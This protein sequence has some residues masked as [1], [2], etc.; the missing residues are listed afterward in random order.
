MSRD[1]AELEAT[2]ERF[3]AD[4]DELRGNLH[5]ELGWAPK[6]LRWIVPI[7]ALAAGVVAGVALKRNL[8]RPRLAAPAAKMSKSATSPLR[9]RR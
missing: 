5:E 3:A 7:V 1:R 8:P 2:R 6:G 4:L 9:R